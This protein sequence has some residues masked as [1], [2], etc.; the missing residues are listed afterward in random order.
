MRKVVCEWLKMMVSHAHVRDGA[1]LLTTMSEFIPQSSHN[2]FFSRF[3]IMRSV[4]ACERGGEDLASRF[5]ERAVHLC[6]MRNYG[7]PGGGG[8]TWDT[9]LQRYL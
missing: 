6:C 9:T 7:D 2:S 8:H 5:D 4:H 3:S 1:D